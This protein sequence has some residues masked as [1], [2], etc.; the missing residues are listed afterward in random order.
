MR[1]INQK[2]KKKKSCSRISEGELIHSYSPTQT[3]HKLHG[4]GSCRKRGTI[5]HAVVEHGSL[6]PIFH[7][8]RSHHLPI[9]TCFLQ[10]DPSPSCQRVHAR[11]V[12]TIAPSRELPSLPAPLCVMNSSPSLRP[13]SNPP[14][15]TEVLSTLI[16]PSSALLVS[17]C[18]RQNK[19]SQ[20][21][22]ILIP[23]I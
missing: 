9:H 17:G 3:I 7:S 12:V 11:P 8:F 10:A 6:I 19:G 14:L 21:V 2:E 20:E 5:L 1:K 23:R 4:D 16:V 18:G 15:P 22:H 13:N